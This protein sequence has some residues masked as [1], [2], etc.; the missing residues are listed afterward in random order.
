MSSLIEFHP[1]QCDHPVKWLLNWATRSRRVWNA[2]GIFVL[3]SAP[4]TF[5]RVRHTRV[6]PLSLY[7]YSI[8]SRN[9]ALSHICRASFVSHDCHWRR[10]TLRP[11]GRGTI[12]GIGSALAN[13]YRHNVWSLGN[14]WK[15]Q[16]RARGSCSGC[17][18][19]GWDDGEVNEGA[20]RSVMVLDAMTK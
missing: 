19:S 1:S 3:T 13:T 18:R 7:I 4:P 20:S 6:F 16:Y 11:Y 10:R 5:R 8:L 9:V 15:R 2:V 17:G 12:W 14:A